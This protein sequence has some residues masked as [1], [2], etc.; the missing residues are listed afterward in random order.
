MSILDEW[1]DRWNAHDEAV[2][3]SSVQFNPD[4]INKRSGGSRLVGEGGIDEQ[5]LQNRRQST[6]S[7]KYHRLMAPLRTIGWH[8]SKWAR[9]EVL[10]EQPDKVE[11]ETT[12][13]R[14]TVDNKLLPIN[15]A[16]NSN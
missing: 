9:R 2:W 5:L 16:F 11:L 6:A 4:N 3:T 8:H 7:D 15:A 12:C 13:L 1:M 14:Y 10:L